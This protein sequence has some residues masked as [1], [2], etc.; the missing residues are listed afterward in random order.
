[1]KIR[2]LWLLPILLLGLVLA[3][4]SNKSNTKKSA[5]ALTKTQVV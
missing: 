5:I 2:K 4:C 3:G 1:M